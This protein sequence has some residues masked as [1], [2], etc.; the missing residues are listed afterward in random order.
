MALESRDERVDTGLEAYHRL[1]VRSISPEDIS[2]TRGE[3]FHTG[4]PSRRRTLAVW[5]ILLKEAKMKRWALFLA[6]RF[7]IALIVFGIF[8][9]MAAGSAR[10]WPRVGIVGQFSHGPVLNRG[11]VAE[12]GAKIDVPV[13]S[14]NVEGSS[15]HY[16]REQ[17]ETGNQ[18]EGVQSRSYGDKKME[19][20][21]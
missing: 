11:T 17:V 18:P 9:I 10:A 15:E 1:P 8:S 4:F 21:K 3:A 20:R 2:H 16:S 19:D 7:G 12:Q 5:G 6:R 14:K 13:N